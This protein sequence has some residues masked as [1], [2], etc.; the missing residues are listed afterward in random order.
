MVEKVDFQLMICKSCLYFIKMS[1]ETC[2]FCG[3]N[4]QVKGSEYVRLSYEQQIAF[5]RMSLIIEGV[6]KRTR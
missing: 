4:P 3:I 5:R 1:E 2:P 6:F